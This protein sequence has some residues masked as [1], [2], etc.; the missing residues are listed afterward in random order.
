MMKKDKLIVLLGPT[1]VG[2]TNLAIALAQKLDT[3][4]ISGDSMLVYRGMDIGTAKPSEA[5][6]TGVPHHLIDILEPQDEFNV[7]RFKEMATAS[8]AA[9]NR[10]GRIPILAGGT[11]LYVRSLLEDYRF[12]EAPGDDAYRVDLER[13]AQTHGKEYVHELL[14]QVDPETADRLHVNDF[15]RVIRA[16]EVRRNGEFISREKN[17][18]EE[19]CYDATVIGLTMERAQ[20][21]DRIN[22]RVE[23]MLENGLVDEVRALTKAGVPIDAQSM[24][25]IGYKEIAAHLAGEISLE[26]AAEQIKKSTRHFAKRQLTW[27]RRMSYIAWYDVGAFS[28]QVLLEKVYTKLAGKFSSE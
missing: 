16:L 21:Y 13:L 18:T 11:G 8:I 24:R 12:N 20:L 4:I 23:L 15:R 3:E 28:E 17:A 7:T 2:K 26:N 10:S 27:F 25:G 5:E 9:V 6:M 22:R 14:R 19:L 1:A